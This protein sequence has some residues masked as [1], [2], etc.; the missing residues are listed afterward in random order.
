MK[1][2]V[3]ATASTSELQRGLGVFDV[4]ALGL[5]GVIGSGI[6]LLPGAAAAMMGPAS[7]LSFIFAGFLCFL[8]AL[9]FAEAGS[10]FSGTGG[11]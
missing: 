4:A 6:F 7:I 11:P 5:N 8:I 10:R 3:S 2:D 9:C 1:H